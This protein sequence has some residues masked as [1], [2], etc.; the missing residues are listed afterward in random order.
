MPFT[1]GAMKLALQW[2]ERVRVEQR[3]GTREWGKEVRR[4]NTVVVR[5][6]AQLKKEVDTHRGPMGG[7]WLAGERAGGEGGGRYKA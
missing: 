6:G 2:G 7:G 1:Y 5:G 4:A 3:G